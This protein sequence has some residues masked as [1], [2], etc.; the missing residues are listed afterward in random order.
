[1]TKEKFSQL[2]DKII[3]PTINNYLK[4]YTN[5]RSSIIPRMVWATEKASRQFEGETTP[6]IREARVATNASM[7]ANIFYFL[8]LHSAS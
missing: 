7:L 8:E 1:M 3:V 5:Y 2:W 4:K 6:T